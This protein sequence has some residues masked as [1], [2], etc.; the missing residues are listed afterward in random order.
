MNA[1]AMLRVLAAALGAAALA[2]AGALAHEQVVYAQ[3]SSREVPLTYG[4][5]VSIAA[6]VLWVRV[7]RSSWGLVPAGVCAMSWSTSTL[8]ISASSSDV[9]IAA[10]A[11]GYAYVIAGLVCALLA[12]A[13]PDRA[14]MSALRQM[15]ADRTD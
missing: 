7:I 12:V 14:T 6:V 9:V 2:C 10:N 4:M 3:V 11:V 5:V 15:R 13:W 1:R 8:L